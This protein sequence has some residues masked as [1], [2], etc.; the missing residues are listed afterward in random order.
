VQLLISGGDCLTATTTETGA[1]LWRGGGINNKKGNGRRRL[2]APRAER[3]R[4]GN[5]ALVCGPKQSPAIAYRMDLSGDISE[6]GR[7]WVLRRKEHARHL[8][9]PRLSTENSMRSMATS[10]P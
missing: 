3:G 6:K 4:V 7:A 2:H 9:H 8:H 5:I 10:R 1:E